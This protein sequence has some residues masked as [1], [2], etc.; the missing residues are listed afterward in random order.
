[1]FHNTN[2]TWRVKWWEDKRQ[3]CP[4]MLMITCVF[5]SEKSGPNLELW[6]GWTLRWNFPWRVGHFFCSLWVPSAIECS[7]LSSCVMSYFLLPVFVCL[8]CPFSVYTC[9]P[10]VYHPLCIYACLPYLLFVHLCLLCTCAC[11]SALMFRLCSCFIL[12]CF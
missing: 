3:L 11:Y 9:V 10:F 12:H 6:L 7:V 1:M 2:T 4:A 8:S 5:M